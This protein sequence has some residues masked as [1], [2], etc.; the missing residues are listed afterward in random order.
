M[1]ELQGVSDYQWSGPFGQCTNISET[2][3]SEDT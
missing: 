2:D 3:D 1:S